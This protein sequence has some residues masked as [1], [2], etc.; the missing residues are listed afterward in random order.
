MSKKTKTLRERLAQIEIDGIVEAL[1][2]SHGNIA[3]AARVCGYPL[4][5]FWSKLYQN[6]IDAEKYRR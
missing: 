2:R 1:E 6:K 3:E 5:T 4:R